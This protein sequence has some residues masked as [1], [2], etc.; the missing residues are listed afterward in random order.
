M[1][2]DTNTICKER[3]RERQRR[4]WAKKTLEERRRLRLRYALNT[5]LKAEVKKAD[6]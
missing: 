5:V 4:F 1:A 2:Q 6:A 3:N